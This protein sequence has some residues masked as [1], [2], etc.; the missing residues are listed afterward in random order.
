MMDKATD[1]LVEMLYETYNSLKFHKNDVNMLRRMN[2][3]LESDKEFYIGRQMEL[4][5][6]ISRL[7]SFNKSQ[8][9]DENIVITNLRKQIKE[10]EEKLCD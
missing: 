5:A 2:K 1:R 3:E 7:E 9:L 4:E 6:E 10:L 8:L